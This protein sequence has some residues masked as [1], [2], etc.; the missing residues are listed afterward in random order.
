MDIYSWWLKFYYIIVYLFVPLNEIVNNI[1]VLMRHFKVI[2]MPINCH[3]LIAYYL[4]RHTKI[5]RIYFET[6]GFK[7]LPQLLV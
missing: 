5:I 6:S 1:L 2:D 7:I 4:V 3:F